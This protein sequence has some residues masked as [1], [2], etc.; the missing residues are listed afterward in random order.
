MAF[1]RP[2]PP[3]SALAA[4][5]TAHG[6]AVNAVGF[7]PDGRLLATGTEA[8]VLLRPVVGRLDQPLVGHSLHQALA[9]ELQPGGTA[10]PRTGWIF[11]AG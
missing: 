7:S 5:L 3:S 2:P 11:S 1:V 8:T 6:K 4:I 9:A 10:H